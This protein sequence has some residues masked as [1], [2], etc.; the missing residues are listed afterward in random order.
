MAVPVTIVTPV[1]NGERYIE[2]TLNSVLT[3]NYRNL[4]YI[5][6]DDGST[7]RTPDIVKRYASRMRVLQQE[8]RGEPSAVNAGVDAASHDIVAIVNADDP[9]LPGL[10]EAAIQTFA[11]D[12]ALVAVYPDWQC[13]DEH[14]VVAATNRTPDFDFRLML[15]EHYCIPGPGAFFRRAAFGGEPARS[16][17]YPLNGDF[18]AW[19]RLGVRGPMRRIPQVFAS[20][21]RHGA[22]TSMTNRSAAM[23][24]ARVGVIESFFARTDLPASLRALERQ[25]KSAA[26]YYAAI[27]ALHDEH[28][29]ARRYLWR[30]LAY[31]V[32]WPRRIAPGRRRSLKLMCYLSF[33]PASRPFKG[34]YGRY[35]DARGV[36][37]ELGV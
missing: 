22:N 13:I 2:E 3:Q 6:V 25:A 15:E 20:W 5:V 8:N 29:P 34:F 26:N 28:V 32:F 23:A 21:R 10:V 14:G 17:K 19:L 35:L 7:D 36:D 11:E 33:L 18:E 4:E 12:D 27:L 9:I 1:Y 16:S 30:S 24:E 31:R 37:H